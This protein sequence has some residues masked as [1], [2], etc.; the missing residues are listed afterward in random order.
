MVLDA[1]NPAEMPGSLNLR[2][3]TRGEE[4]DL[5]RAY[6][7]RQLPLPRLGQ[8]RTV[9]VEPE[10]ETGYPDLVVAYWHERTAAEWPSE[11]A[12]LRRADLQVMHGLFI[13]GPSSAARLQAAHRSSFHESLERLVAAGMVYRKGTLWYARS[14]QSIFAL[15]RLVAIEA[16][17]G[18]WRRG[19]WQAVR[20]TWFAS[21][22]YLLAPPDVTTPE[23]IGEAT[24][25]GIGLL[26]ANAPFSRPVV[27][28]E[29]AP[30]PRSY[31]S[32]LF[33]EWVWRLSH[34]IGG[35]ENR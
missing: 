28:A 32:W 16:K 13:D 9:F 5:V 20:N 23:L 29:S 10:V 21:E 6:I 27:E 3:P 26:Q 30:L 1:D 24:R 11:R 22:S 14:V 8:V 18:D 31:A 4:H 33:N 34:G 15:R 25:L 35:S 2:T 19:A 7:Q 17:V 12:N